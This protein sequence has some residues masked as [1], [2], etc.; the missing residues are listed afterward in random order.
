MKSEQEML[1]RIKSH[2]CRTLLLDTL[3]G[4]SCG[5]LFCDTLVAYSCETL[6]RDTLLRHCCLT[7][8]LDTLVAHSGKKHSLN[9]LEHS[10]KTLLLETPCLTHLEHL[11]VLLYTAKLAQSTSQYYFALQILHEALP[12]TTLYYKACTRNSPVLLCTAK[13]EKIHRKPKDMA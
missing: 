2:S 5:T 7:L 13:L 1:D 8:L 10:C 12:S 9:T 6:L 3:L 11:A 4:H